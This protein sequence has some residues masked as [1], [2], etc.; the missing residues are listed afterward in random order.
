MASGDVR[1]DDL[2][3]VLHELAERIDW[4][5]EQLRNMGQA[6]GYHVPPRETPDVPPEVVELARTGRRI[7]A[8]KLY[9]EATGASLEQ[10]RAKIQ[11]L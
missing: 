9:R 5:E 2:R 10:A 6:L 7:E 4:L 11:G 1:W 8:I 3:P